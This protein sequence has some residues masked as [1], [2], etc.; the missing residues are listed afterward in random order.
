MEAKVNKTKTYFIRLIAV[1]VGHFMNDFYMN[2][3]PPI[4]FLFVPALGLNLS[5][6]A[7]V[8]FVITSSGCFFQPIIGYFVDKRGKPSLLIFSL[9]WIS[10]WMSVAGIITN[11]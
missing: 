3:I 6:Q 4:L 10:F 7:F 11:Y 9:I 8:A 5:Q 1:S 2:L